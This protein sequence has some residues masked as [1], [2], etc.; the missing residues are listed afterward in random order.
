MGTGLD[1]GLGGGGGHEAVVFC[2]LLLA[3]PIG[4]PPL[5]SLTPV[6]PT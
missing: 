5:P 2:C 4:L 3:V 6:E 1:M